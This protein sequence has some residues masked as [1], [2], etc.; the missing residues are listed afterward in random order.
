M[1]VAPFP[2][3]VKNSFFLAASKYMCEIFEMFVMRKISGC[4]YTHETAPAGRHSWVCNI[5]S[6]KASLALSSALGT[7]AS[8]NPCSST[9]SAR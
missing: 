7:I 2:C 9:N 3:L 6:A 1:S 4:K 5:F 8:R